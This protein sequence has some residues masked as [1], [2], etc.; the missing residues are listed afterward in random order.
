MSP[1]LQCRH[2]GEI[3][4]VYEPFMT[5]VEGQLLE[6]SRLGEPPPRTGDGPAYHEACL[7]SARLQGLQKTRPVGPDPLEPEAG[8]EQPR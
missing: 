4:G 1:T 6:A 7:A 5:L 3:I 8:G 2:C